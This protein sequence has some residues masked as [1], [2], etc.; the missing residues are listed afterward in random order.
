MDSRIRKTLKASPA[1]LG[2]LPVTLAG[3]AATT[4]ITAFGPRLSRDDMRAV[5]RRHRVGAETVSA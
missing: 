3:D 4:L 1:E 5:G 2:G